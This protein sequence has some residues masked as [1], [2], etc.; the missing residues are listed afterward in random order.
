MDFPELYDNA[1]FRVIP[2]SPQYGPLL[3]TEMK[4]SECGKPGEYTA[5]PESFATDLKKAQKHY[6]ANLGEEL[7]H[8]T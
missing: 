4:E 8:D 7:F 1:D 3:F 2:D 6:G 5:I